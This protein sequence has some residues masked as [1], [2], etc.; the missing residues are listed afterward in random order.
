MSQQVT[1][2]YLAGIRDGREY[3]RRFNPGL[4]E[5][6][7]ILA[8]IRETAHSFGPGEVKDMLKGERDFWTNQIKKKELEQ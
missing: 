1:A 7:Q 3:L 5:M 6:R 8:N 4:D 2:E